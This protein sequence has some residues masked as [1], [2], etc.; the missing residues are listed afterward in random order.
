M[1][2]ALF[3]SSTSLPTRRLQ[4]RSI[5]PRRSVRACDAAASSID[6]APVDFDNL[7]ARL[8]HINKNLR[9]KAGVTISENAGEPEIQRLMDLLD[10]ED[11]H[12]RRTAVNTLG[13]IGLPTMH[14][15]IDLM[16]SSDNSTVRASCAKAIGAIVLYYPECRAT[17]PPNAL[18][19]LRGAL[20]DPD[21]VTKLSVVGCLGM[22]G[23]DAKRDDNDTPYSGCEEAL[24]ILFNV[25][26]NVADAG[27][28]ANAIAAIS[29]I[30]QN[31]TP[32]RKQEVIQFFREVATIE[33]SD[34]ESGMSY[35][36]QMA[37]GNLSQLESGANGPIE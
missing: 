15:L 17:F 24:G 33:D 9:K 16:G 28:G 35:V 36:K 30:A 8:S 32:S 23:S 29:Q 19:A 27:I 1:N 31:G 5:S 4:P 13:M 22:V 14:K 20:D 37:E 10:N 7:F 18:A 21:P 25:A 11:V 12:L 6:S 26:R 2:S 3:V 34:P